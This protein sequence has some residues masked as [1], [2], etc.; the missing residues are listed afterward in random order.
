MRQ[1]QDKNDISLLKQ[2]LGILPEPMV[3]PA[4]VVVIG[5]PGTGKSFFCSKLVEKS[6]FCIIESDAMRK[7]LIGKPDYSIQESARLFKACHGLIEDLLYNGVPVIFDATNLAESN[8]ERLYYI[9]DKT[10]AKLVLVQLDAPSELVY[11]RLKDR[12]EGTDPENKSDADWEVYLN[13]KQRAGRIK[14][15]HIV[16]D[17]S[18]DIEPV[19]DKIIRII[20]K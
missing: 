10:K 16:V 12:K 19:I 18:R 2:S 6:P 8:R 15:N 3:S 17:T 11:K 14:R 9:G 1:D 4:F 7:Y 20:N 5:L 13:M